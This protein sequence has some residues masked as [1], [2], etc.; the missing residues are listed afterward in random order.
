M[1]VLKLYRSVCMDKETYNQD[2]IHW[3]RVDKHALCDAMDNI[4]GEAARKGDSIEHVADVVEALYEQYPGLKEYKEE[5]FRAA[6]LGSTVF[7]SYLSDT[8]VHCMPIEC[9]TQAK[10]IED[11]KEEIDEN[12]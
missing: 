7:G 5:R 6:C 1:T 11:N 3:D 12:N 9:H 4:L 2:F 8:E 10:A